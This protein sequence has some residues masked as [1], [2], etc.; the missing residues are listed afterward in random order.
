MQNAT[1]TRKVAGE[2][3]G[4]AAPVLRMT[5]TAPD[6]RLCRQRGQGGR[7]ATND[8]V[9]KAVTGKDPDTKR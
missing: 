8:T 9:G 5:T 2:H 7:M 3:Q 4:T 1:A 6:D